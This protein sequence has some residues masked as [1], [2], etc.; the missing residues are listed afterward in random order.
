MEILGRLLEFNPKK[1]EYLL[2]KVIYS[3]VR[4][5]YEDAVKYYEKILEMGIEDEWCKAY[6]EKALDRLH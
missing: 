1:V 5:R 6:Y 4:T 3:Y 2:L